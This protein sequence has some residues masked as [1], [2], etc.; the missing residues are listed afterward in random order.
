MAPRGA[1][2]SIAGARPVPVKAAIAAPPGLAVTDTVPLRGPACAG[3]NRTV[4]SQRSPGSMIASLEVPG[5]AIS[6][7][8]L[9]VNLM[10]DWLGDLLNPRLRR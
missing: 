6:L 9:A 2:A 10:G 4:T 5:V 7:T 1:R 3:S 8:V